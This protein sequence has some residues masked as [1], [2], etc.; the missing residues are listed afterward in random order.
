ML[1][2]HQ[3]AGVLLDM[4]ALDPDHLGIGQPGLLVS[5]DRQRTFADNRMIKLR[6]LVALR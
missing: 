2:V 4:D 5:L 1:I 3:L 6:N